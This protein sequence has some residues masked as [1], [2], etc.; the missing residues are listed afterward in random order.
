[1]RDVYFGLLGPDAIKIAYR[2]PNRQLH[3]EPTVGTDGAYL[4]IERHDPHNEPSIGSAQS[5]TNGTPIVGVAWHTGDNCGVLGAQNRDRPF[6]GCQIHEYVAPAVR[7]PNE[8]AVRSP[9]TVRRLPRDAVSV[10]FTARVAVRNA[11][12]HYAIQLID[13]PHRDPGAPRNVGCGAAGTGTGTDA[14]IRAGQRIT[15]TI[16][17]GLPCYGIARGVVELVTEP[18]PQ[19]GPPFGIAARHLGIGRIVGRFSYLISP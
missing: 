19:S 10:R 8:T 7:V 16:G 18:G 3:I 4:V 14:D 9:L 13:P 2:T 17:P 15:F 1:V 5:I 11:R 6:F 12:S